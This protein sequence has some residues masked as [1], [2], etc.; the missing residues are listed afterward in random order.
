LRLAR[1]QNPHVRLNRRMVRG[2]DARVGWRARDHSGNPALRRSSPKCS[3]SSRRLQTRAKIPWLIVNHDS[4]RSASTASSLALIGRARHGC[5]Q[6]RQSVRMAPE[7]IVGEPEQAR[8]A[9]QIEPIKPHLRLEC[10]D[11]PGRLSGHHQCP[12]LMRPAS[13][14]LHKTRPLRWGATG[15]RS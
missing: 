3:P 4:M 8:H 5:L 11:C 13:E 15:Q 2:A 6:L 9:R 7:Q 1:T 14:T 12:C 10:L